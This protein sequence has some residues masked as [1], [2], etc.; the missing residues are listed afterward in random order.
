MIVVSFEDYS[1]YNPIEWKWNFYPNDVTFVNGTDENSQNP[2]VVFNLSYPY[3]V[4]FTAT[5]L[6]GSSTV[7]KPKFIHSGG[8]YLPFAE[9]FESTTFDSKAWTIDNPDGEKTWEITSVGGNEPGT[10][11]AYVNI[12]SY[13]G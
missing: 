8:L 11:A 9:D 4:T 6:N 3:Q 10:K 2:E 7:I 5:N 13:N 12:K 1:I